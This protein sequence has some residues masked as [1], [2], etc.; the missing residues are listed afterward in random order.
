MVD[1]PES[2]FVV[3]SYFKD[4]FNIHGSCVMAGRTLSKNL[5]GERVETL[6]A[7]YYNPNP[8]ISLVFKNT[9]FF[10]LSI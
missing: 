2:W 10:F 5:E 6:N 4:R 1:L 3:V 9:S 8:E 7:R